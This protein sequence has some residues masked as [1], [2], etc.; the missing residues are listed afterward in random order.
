MSR[1]LEDLIPILAIKAQE[2]IK[3]VNG[4]GYEILITCTW[5]S[6]AEQQA[7][8]EQGRT[9]PGPIVTYAKAG[10]SWHNYA[11]ALD[12]V[13]LK[14]GNPDWNDR[15]KFK[16]VGEIGEDLGLKWG[17]RFKKP[18][19]LPHLEMTFGF[20]LG[21]VKMLYEQGGIKKVWEECNKRYEANLWP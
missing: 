6:F 9:M 1:K 12:F 21:E 11:L 2:L 19:D 4:L 14:N 8:Y 18:V 10:E 7:L 20:P 17:G 5:R 3:K 16:I 15:E 13:P